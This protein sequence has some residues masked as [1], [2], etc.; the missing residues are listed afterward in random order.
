MTAETK[1][2][3]GPDACPVCRAGSLA[4][5][6]L[7][8][9]S[10]GV[11]PMNPGH[12]LTYRHRI[13]RVCDRCG[14]GMLERLSHDCFNPDWEDEPWDTIL[15]YELAPADVD[16]L[17]ALIREFCSQ[18]LDPTCSCALHESLRASCDA[19]PRDYSS[20]QRACPITLTPAGEP[21]RFLHLGQRRHHPTF[22]PFGGDPAPPDGFARCTICR[23]LLTAAELGA[24]CPGPPAESA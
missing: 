16:R 5:D 22:N 23:A 20:P 1:P 19:L 24:L 3:R 4:T 13:V 10:E 17:R 18:P 9:E 6:A 12:E 15:T 14:G 7:I 11:P 8:L 21:V 2:Y